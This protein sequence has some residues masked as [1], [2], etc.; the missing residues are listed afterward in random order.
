MTVGQGSRGFAVVDAV[1]EVLCPHEVIE[2][3][4][5]TAEASSRAMRPNFVIVADPGR[6]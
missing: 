1:V 2:A 6:L 3:I 5:I 4:A